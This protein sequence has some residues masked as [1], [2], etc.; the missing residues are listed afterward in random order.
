[1]GYLALLFIVVPAVEL[2]LLIEV[3]SFFGTLPTFALIVVTGMVGAA[4]ARRQGLSVLGRLR[5]Q[6][7][8][9]QWPGDTIADG[10]IILVAGALLVTPGILTDVTGFLM[11]IPTTRTLIRRYLEKRLQRAVATGAATMYTTGAAPRP[12]GS[13]VV[14]DVTPNTSERR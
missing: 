7:Q 11:L 9:G 12:N 13:G 1:M 5:S 3:G 2:A 8:T 14:I 10:A 4:L 6:M